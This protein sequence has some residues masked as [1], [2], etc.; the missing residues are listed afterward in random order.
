[1]IVGAAAGVLG[2]ATIAFV[3]SD[4]RKPAA[5]ASVAPVSAPGAAN[6]VP[7]IAPI[8]SPPGPA[9]TVTKTAD[10]PDVPT[11]AETESTVPRVVTRAKIRVSPPNPTP[12]TVATSMAPTTPTAGSAASSALKTPSEEAFALNERG[13]TEMF[14]ERYQESISLFTKAL[15]LDPQSKYRFNLATAYFQVGEM[16]SAILH[17]KLVLAEHAGTSRGDF[18]K[19]LL[20]RI[21][22]ECAEQKLDCGRP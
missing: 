15:A 5:T 1:M 3:M 20:D 4:D 19:R 12:N 8:Q 16:N 17:A 11:A 21:Y 7:P 22:A 10:A 2:G 13:K 18:A 14:A 6:P 9:P